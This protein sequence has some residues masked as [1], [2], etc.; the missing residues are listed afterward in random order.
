MQFSKTELVG[1]SPTCLL[2][3][4]RIEN[5]RNDSVFN[6]LRPAAHQ[7]IPLTKSRLAIFRPQVYQTTGAG[8]ENCYGVKL[9]RD[10]RQKIRLRYRRPRRKR[11]NFL[12]R[13]RCFRQLAKPQEKQ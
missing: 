12:L 6:E 3:R 8:E 1:H 7:K 5:C 10:T 13:E 11:N 9:R 2:I 4:R